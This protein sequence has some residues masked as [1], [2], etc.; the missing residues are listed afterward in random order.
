LAVKTLLRQAFDQNDSLYD[1]Q[2]SNPVPDTSEVAFAPTLNLTPAEESPIINPT[3]AFEDSTGSTDSIANSE[4]PDASEEMI[5]TIPPAEKTTSQGRTFG[6][7][8]A[9]AVLGLATFLV[10]PKLFSDVSPTSNPSPTESLQTP[11]TDNPIATVEL[12]DVQEEDGLA[13]TSDYNPTDGEAGG[14][15][16]SDG[17]LLAEAMKMPET[18]T[19]LI[20]LAQGNPENHTKDTKLP[21]TDPLNT[22]V[23]EGASGTGVGDAGSLSD[24]DRNKLSTKKP[25]TVIKED[26][27]KNRNNKKNSKKDKEE[28]VSKKTSPIKV[29]MNFSNGTVDG[30]CEVSDIRKKLLRRKESFKTCHYRLQKSGETPLGTI[31]IGWQIDE[32]GRV[33]TLKILNK[34]K[35]SEPLASC[36]RSKIQ[37]LRFTRPNSGTCEI[38]WAFSFTP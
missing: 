7:F 11:S 34:D 21:P 4:A 38:D 22:L 31:N 36:L 13:G 20:G 28:S 19:P 10:F 23:D 24:E 2:V 3:L 29:K 6:W 14:L 8:L 5:F 30:F 27:A 16:A 33:K 18:A 37:S 26:R 1:E 35:H 9:A 12:L 25:D 15:L 32:I 17:L